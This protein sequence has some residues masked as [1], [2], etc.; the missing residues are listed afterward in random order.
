SIEIAIKEAQADF[1]AKNADTYSKIKG[2]TP[3]T[4]ADV[5]N[6]KSI[7]SAFESKT[8]DNKSYVPY[9]NKKTGKVVFAI[10]VDSVVKDIDGLEVTGT[11]LTADSTTAVT[12]LTFTG[13]G[14][15][16]STSST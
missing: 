16:T 13:E 8:I 6:A 2:N 15:E 1:T 7:K 11:K 14:T 12:E 10:E 9:W 4:V 3:P 5:A